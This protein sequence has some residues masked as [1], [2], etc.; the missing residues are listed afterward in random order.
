MLKNFESQIPAEREDGTGPLASDNLANERDT[1]IDIDSLKK[2]AVSSLKTKNVDRFAGLLKKGGVLREQIVRDKEIREIA[3]DSYKWLLSKGNSEQ[4]R[5]IEHLLE[6]TPE[7]RVRVDVNDLLIFLRFRK[8]DIE[9]LENRKIT[10]EE[11]KDPEVISQVSEIVKKYLQKKKKGTAL[12][13]ESIF[14]LPKENIIN[15]LVE[16]RV[17]DYYN[18]DEVIDYKERFSLPD[19]F[20]EQILKESFFKHHASIEGVIN[21]FNFSSNPQR[22]FED[23]QVSQLVVKEIIKSIETV[24]IKE[25]NMLF[26]IVDVPEELRNRIDDE[27]KISKYSLIKS[28]RYLSINSEISAILPKTMQRARELLK[29]EVKNN[30]DIADYFVE[31]LNSYFQEPWVKECLE[32]A[33]NWQS[34]ALK[35]FHAEDLEWFNAKWSQ[36]IL[37]KVAEK[38]KENSGHGTEKFMKNDIYED[39]FY[40]FNTREAHVSLA[41]SDIMTGH[42]GKE[43]IEELGIEGKEILSLIAKVNIIIEDNYKKFIKNV[44]LNR[45]ISDEDRESLINPERGMVKMSF[46][47]DNVKKFVARLITQE[48]YEGYNG[49]SKS[50]GSKE[51]MD[52]IDNVNSEDNSIENEIETDKK[53]RDLVCDFIDSVIKEGFQKYLKVHEVDIPLYDKLYEEFDGL[54]ETGRNPLEVYL[55]RDGIYAWLGRRSQDV[56]RRRKMGPQ[57]RKELKRKGEIL[58]INPKYIVYPRYFRDNI[59]YQT[60]RE[61]LEQEGISTSSDPFFYDTGYTGTIPEQIMRIMDFDEDDIERRIRLLSAQKVNRRVRGVSENARNEIVEYIEHN[62]KLEESAEGLL[63]DKETGRIRH[64]AMAT[65]AEEQFYFLMIKQAISRHYWLQEKLYHKP[66]ENINI[67]SE[68]YKIRIREEYAKFLPESFIENPKVFL[69]KHAELIKGSSGEGKY[70]DEEVRLFKLNNGVEIIAKRVELRKAKE[71]RKEFAILIAAKKFGLPTADP[72]GFLSGKEDAS[73]NYLLME[74][75]EGYS[76]RKFE[77]E[78]KNMGNYSDEEIKAIMQEVANKNKEVAELF[79]S[80]IKIDKRWRI[81]DVMIEFNKE[82]G[83]IGN[84]IPI[85]WERADNFNPSSPKEIDEIN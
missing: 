34:V 7:E 17:A 5:K 18:W 24:K 60:K 13:I 46:L 26:D 54:R 21:R 77:K 63:L 67:D 62:A 42:G 16:S 3:K 78:L 43:K 53:N 85:D 45:N 19:S 15:I 44:N 11:K 64:V 75:I 79:R 51:W 6:L 29:E 65:S 10:E 50:I 14:N 30:I 2:E 1:S 27:A 4:A 36:E 37:D 9:A 28:I 33:I 31:N 40:R 58:E 8:I 71:A 47:Q 48:Y 55:G 32:G 12:K 39:D 59:D 73:G 22:L 56:A 61:F 38:A 35:I 25:V 68:H 82:T 74:K 84:V 69:E 41:L 83:E 57:K 49:F 72:V 66:S 81:K 23:H 70:P 20:T 80:T 76:G 52:K